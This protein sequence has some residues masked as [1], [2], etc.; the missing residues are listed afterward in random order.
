MTQRRIVYLTAL[1][2][3]IVFYWANRSWLSAQLLLIVAVLPWLSLLLSL[4]AM[5]SCKVELQ[6]PDRVT[7]GFPARVALEIRCRFPVALIMGKL[8]ICSLAV[9]KTQ[10]LKPGSA[11]PTAHCGAFRIQCYRL[12]IAD[13]LGLFRLPVRLRE[14]RLVLVRPVPS[15]PAQMPDMSRYL[16]GTTRPK[17]GGGYAENHELRLY[18][19]GDNLQ[20]IH[21]KLSSKTGKLIIREPME[22]LQDAAVLTME[23]SGRPDVLDR[24]LGLLLGMSTHL[25]EKSIKHR[26]FCYTGKGMEIC[27]VSTEQEALDAVDRILQLPTVAADK[28]PPYPKAIWR[29]HIGGDDSEN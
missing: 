12:W 26:I 19:P 22:T 27:S 17:P 3:G 24:K 6:C 7:V 23:L 1:T 25:A 13:Y 8:R 4:P 20:Q 2:A 9:G 29:Y 11:L 16:C 5:V 28:T 18:R 15:L 10:K 14:D 21:W